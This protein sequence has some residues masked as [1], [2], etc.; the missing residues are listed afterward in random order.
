[1]IFC[2]NEA[3]Y[4]LRQRFDKLCPFQIKS[5]YWAFYN[6]QDESPSEN[7]ALRLYEN[8]AQSNYLLFEVFAISRWSSRALYKLSRELLKY[9]RWRPFVLGKTMLH[10]RESLRKIQL[11]LSLGSFE[12]LFSLE[13]LKD[14]TNGN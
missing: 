7:L 11:A 8:I 4:G 1:M 2:P 14:A 10:I 9:H 13:Y 5:L 3:L 12:S 6:F